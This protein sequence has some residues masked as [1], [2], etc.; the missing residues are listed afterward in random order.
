MELMK[1]V[2]AVS[3]GAD[4]VVLLDLLAHHRPGQLV[5]AHVDHG[6]RAGSAADARFVEGLAAQYP[7]VEYVSSRLELG[8]NASESTAR[9][10]RYAVLRRIAAWYDAP[11]VTAHHQDDVV[12]TVALNLLRGTRWRGLAGLDTAGILR[13]LHP[14]TKQQLLHYAFQHR[15]EW[16]E[17]ESN[18]SDRYTR[19]QLRRRLGQQV[20]PQARQAVYQLWLNQRR[21]RHQIELASW[22]FEPQLSSRYFLTNIDQSVA[23]ELLQ[24]QVQRL[25]GG[26]LSG[27]LERLWLAIKTGR[28]GTTWQVGGAVQVKLTAKNVTIERVD[29][30]KRKEDCEYGRT[31]AE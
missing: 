4:S 1:Y 12:E 11:I 26:L 18:H 5:V 19:N 7:G 8:P 14:W 3:G 30:E 25:G 27:Q 16:C 21:L 28:P 29:L 24:Q 15:L 31:K 20:S 6:I 9:Q 23:Q 10:Q 17:D 13:P 22:Q 2:V